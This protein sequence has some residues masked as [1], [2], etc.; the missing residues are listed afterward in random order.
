MF[1]NLICNTGLVENIS[2]YLHCQA[3]G[4]Q[5]MQISSNV[6]DVIQKFPSNAFRVDAILGCYLSK[7][8]KIVIEQS[9]DGWNITLQTY[10]MQ[11]LKLSKREVHVLVKLMVGLRSLDQA[12]VNVLVQWLQGNELAALV[13]GLK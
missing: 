13:H 7:M 11:W 4:H 8:G 10:T 1:K 9:Y 2:L 3:A 5:Q 12:G 6:V